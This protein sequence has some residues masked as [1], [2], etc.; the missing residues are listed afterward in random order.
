MTMPSNPATPST[1]APVDIRAAVTVATFTDYASA[2]RTVDYLSDNEFPVEHTAIIGTDLALV[3]N[4][5]GRLTT[6]RAGLAGAA[7]GAWFGLLI[8]LILGIF[9]D[10]AWWTLLMTG[11]L[12]GAFW[13]AAF[14]AIAHAMTRGR[15]DFASRSQ[16]QAGRYAVTADAEYADQARHLVARQNWQDST[17][18]Q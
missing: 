9:S 16:L 12:I 17:A 10:S 13:G 8:G 1:S 11:L 18:A 3:E 15:R 7:S 14:G 4:V 6:A 5:L 2:Q